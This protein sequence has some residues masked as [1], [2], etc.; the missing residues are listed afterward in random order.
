MGQIRGSNEKSTLRVLPASTVDD[1]VVY[2]VGQRR[3]KRWAFTITSGIFRYFDK[4][5]EVADALA[6]R[7]P[8]V[9]LES[10][11]ITHGMPYPD[12][13]Q[14]AQE[15]EEIVRM[16][17][18]VPAT[19][20]LVNGRIKV[21]LDAD[22]WQV[23]GSAPQKNLLK[24]SRRDLGYAISRNLSGGTTVSG[25]MTVAA[26]TGIRI[27]ATGGIGGVHRGV[28]ETH[29][30]S[31]D[32]IELSRTPV[33]V[34]SSGVKSILDIPRTLEYLETMGV[35]VGVYRGDNGQFP[36][37]YTRNSGQD[38]HYKFESIEEIVKLLKAN[39]LLGERAGVL[40]GVPIPQE[41][42]LNKLEIEA[43]IEEALQDA[44]QQRI[45]GK[46]VTP[47][48]LGAVLKATKGK[49]LTAS[50]CHLF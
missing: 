10:T 9:A 14:T 26:M 46:A 40:I 48:L 3:I 2:Q 29:D 13:I 30:V 16:E 7:K 5:K 15:V 38:A 47:F 37:F 42:E 33:M 1:D 31:A 12:N 8:V 50:E 19:I 23:L 44:K 39:L 6:T 45:K 4:N 28:E 49:S 18:A 21:G 17:N 41:S 22:D 43:A 35:L 34:F 36:A 11:I 27:F 32:L 20:A 24:I 25:T